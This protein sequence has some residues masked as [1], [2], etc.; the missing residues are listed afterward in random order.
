VAAVTLGVG[1][2]LA[3]TVGNEKGAIRKLTV[4]PEAPRMG[5][6]EAAEAGL[7]QARLVLRD[8]HQG[9]LFL[10]NTSPQPITIELPAAVAAVQAL[11]QLP[12]NGFLNPGA[13]PATNSTNTSSA[14]ATAL[15][16]QQNQ[17]GQ[18]PPGLPSGNGFFSIPPQKT[19]QI[20]VK[21]VC[22]E[23][24]KPDPQPRMTYALLPLENFT[25]NPVLRELLNRFGRESL[26]IP[27]VQ[28][29][30][31]HL[32]DDMDWETLEAKHIRHIGG[33]TTRYFTRNQIHS[34]RQLASEAADAIQKQQSG[35]N[36]AGTGRR[37]S[38]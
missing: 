28:A 26:D 27:A 3:V 31:W 17:Q 13:T 25:T 10:E 2:L 37:K 32:T 35:K 30:T 34:A 5:L 14:Q 9:Q 20:T 24:G 33:H 22:L 8:A 1:L 21:G 19:V 23:H 12:P 4:D 15:G 38:L 36:V 16:F 7:L 11:K 29:A 18:M 6:F